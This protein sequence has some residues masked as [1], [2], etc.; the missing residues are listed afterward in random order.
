MRRIFGLIHQWR[1][2][3]QEQSSH[4]SRLT[5]ALPPEIGQS[6]QISPVHYE[7]FTTYFWR[8]P[9]LC[10]VLAM[11]FDPAIPGQGRLL[12]RNGTF[13]GAFLEGLAHAPRLHEI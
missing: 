12:S 10:T 4:C 1:T 7:S 11:K 5:W 2:G 6:P 3:A 8:M 13:G 9:L